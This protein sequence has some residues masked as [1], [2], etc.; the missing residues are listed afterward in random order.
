MTRFLRVQEVVDMHDLLILEFGGLNGLRD[1]GLLVSAVEAPK[2]SLSNEFL[3]PT[4]FDKAAAYLF[5]ISR[6]HPFIDGN[7]R[8]AA[9][10]A[11]AFL[12]DNKVRL[13]FDEYEFEEL[14]VETSM[15][16]ISKKDISRFFLQSNER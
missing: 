15:G 7:K 16:H 12:E 13:N 14:V 5:H 4:L 1:L 2:A 6:N 9:F 8:T 3:H 10:A 11:L